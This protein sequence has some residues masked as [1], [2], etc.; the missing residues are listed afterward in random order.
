MT[1]PDYIDNAK[2]NTLENVLKTIIED[3]HQLNLDIATGFFRIEAWLRLEAA[4]NQLNSFRLLIGRDP[5]IRPAESDRIDLI[6]YFKRT[7]QQQL[8]NENVR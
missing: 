4:M 1:I 7:L 2:N 3:H 5:A 8:G 6:K